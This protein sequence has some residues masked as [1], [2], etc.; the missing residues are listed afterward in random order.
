VANVAIDIDKEHHGEYVVGMMT[1]THGFVGALLGVSTAA[2]TP[3]L[4]ATAVVIGFLGGT[5][6]D[7][8]LVATHRR[9][10]H[11]P[12]YATGLVAPVAGIAV[13]TGTSSAILL[14]VFTL[15]IAVHCLMDAFGGGVEL[16]PWEATS[17]R[18][19]YNH[20]T[21]RWIRPR[22]W[23]RYAGA[24]EDFLLA[25]ACALPTLAL[26]SGGVQLGLLVVLVCSGVFTVVRR[27]LSTVTERLFS[28]AVEQ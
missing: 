26:T 15:G 21:G 16:R 28:G 17:D 20:A 6:P 13:L 24:P 10:L 2:V 9:S 1:S 7:I 27:R 14:A 3:E 11:F 12:V 8:D 18:G 4:T 5:L 23:V 19:V 25:F 22:R